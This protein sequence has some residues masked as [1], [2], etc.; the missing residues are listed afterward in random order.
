MTRWEGTEDSWWMYGPARYFAPDISHMDSGGEVIWQQHLYDWKRLEGKR[1]CSQNQKL[2]LCLS[3]CQLNKKI[4]KR[5]VNSTQE[6]KIRLDVTALPGP[7][8]GAMEKEEAEKHIL[9]SLCFSYRHSLGKVSV[10]EIS[11]RILFSVSPRQFTNH[12]FSSWYIEY[13]ICKY[14][15]S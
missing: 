12:W 9:V 1:K 2:Q 3:A 7:L 14:P 11:L 15:K 4:N 5:L 6:C 13:I 8:L 10:L